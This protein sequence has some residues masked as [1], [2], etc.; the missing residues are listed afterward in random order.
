MLFPPA[1][2]EY[3]RQS[4]DS[5][6]PWV[7]LR[8]FWSQVVSAIK[9][10]LQHLC[11]L[12]KQRTEKSGFFFKLLS[13]LIKDSTGPVANVFATV[14]SARQTDAGSQAGPSLIKGA[15]WPTGLEAIHLQLELYSP[16][17]QGLFLSSSGLS[18]FS[19]KPWCDSLEMTKGN[20][21]EAGTKG[22]CE[23]PFSTWRD[24]T[25]SRFG[26]QTHAFSS[27]KQIWWR[28]S[29]KC[30]RWTRKQSQ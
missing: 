1:V 16:K 9:W 20:D 24:H 8:S 29:V 19:N 11:D 5:V 13:S 15:R 28:E 3:N 7:R 27:Y 18:L 2:P 30:L 21:S 17:I 22:H 6:H 4:T 12:F 25:T 26:T 10:S 23:Q 14:S